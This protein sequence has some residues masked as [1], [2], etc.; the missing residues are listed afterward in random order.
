MADTEER[1]VYTAMGE[2]WLVRGG[3]VGGCT[4]H[5]IDLNPDKRSFTIGWYVSGT[6]TF[7]FS[8]LYDAAGNPAPAPALSWGSLGAGPVKED[9]W[10]V[11]NGGNTW[12]A[13]QYAGVPGYIFSDDLVHGFYVTKITL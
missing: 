13:K 4:S 9:G 10:I 12:S 5:V 6:R 8:G 11:P 7:D 2:Q 3:G 1:D